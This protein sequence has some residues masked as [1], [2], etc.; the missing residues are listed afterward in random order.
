[1]AKLSLLPYLPKPLYKL[2]DKI[3]GE[4]LMLDFYR[5]HIT[6]KRK[7]GKLKITVM[8]H[9]D[10]VDAKYKRMERYMVKHSHRDF[11]KFSLR[12]A[13]N[14]CNHII[15]QIDEDDHR[16]VQFWTRRKFLY[17][18]YTLPQKERIKLYKN[19]IITLLKNYHFKQI[20]HVYIPKN[21]GQS[22]DGL[23]Y[24]I[25]K[26][27]RGPVINAN[28]Q[29]DLELATEFT[30]KMFTD[31]YKLNPEELNILMG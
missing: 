26:M 13:L 3:E 6:M 21:N 12:Q 19:K 4:Y 29:T 15:F 5:Y 27:D 7:N 10:L 20:D 8:K 28:F 22:K 2:Y 9:Y 30:L 16:F 31:I 14:G 17:M 11:I 25:T 23:Y 1:M 18:D 24:S